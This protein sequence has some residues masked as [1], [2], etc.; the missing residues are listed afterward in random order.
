MTAH[1]G[2]RSSLFA[3]RRPE[4]LRSLYKWPM[5]ME[6]LTGEMS[7]TLFL[8]FGSRSRGAALAPYCRHFYD[9]FRSFLSFFPRFA[10]S[11]FFHRWREHDETLTPLTSVTILTGTRAPRLG[12]SFHRDLTCSPVMS[13]T[14][15]SEAATWIARRLT[16]QCHDNIRNFWCTFIFSKVSK[17]RLHAE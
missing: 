5:Q 1:F 6:M 7:K 4:E 12:S 10:I 16:P 9:D 17:T 15:L 2:F 14:C 3:S 8:Y 13:A 11:P